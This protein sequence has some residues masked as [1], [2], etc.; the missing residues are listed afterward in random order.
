MQQDIN[1]RRRHI[2]A[3]AGIAFFTH[4]YCFVMSLPK[5]DKAQWNDTEVSALID[6]LYEHRSEVGDAGNFKSATLNAAANYI[7]PHLTQG[8]AKTGKMCGTKWSSVRLLLNLI[9]HSHN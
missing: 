6:Y 1:Q 7:G 5:N 3:L 9:S 4:Y 2:T 8:P